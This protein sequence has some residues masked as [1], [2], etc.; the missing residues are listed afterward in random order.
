MADDLRRSTDESLVGYA[1]DLD[2]VVRDQAMTA[3]DQLDRG[4]RLADARVTEQQNALAVDLNENAVERDARRKLHAQGR[5][6]G[7]DGRGGEIVRAQDGHAVL[8]RRRDALREQLDVARDEQHRDARFKQPVEAG[9]PLLRLHLFH[10]ARFDLAHHLNAVGVKI[11]K[12][13]GKLKTGTVYV[14]LCDFDLFKALRAV[15]YLKIKFVDQVSQAYAKFLKLH[16]GSPFRNI[17]YLLYPFLCRV[18]TYS[19][20]A[21]YKT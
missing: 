10:I 21:S 17:S 6:E 13:A 4:L 3:L 7:I 5:N 19:R 9:A 12:K 18:S 1:L 2:R 16:M 15:Y 20:L 8:L 14:V 11:I